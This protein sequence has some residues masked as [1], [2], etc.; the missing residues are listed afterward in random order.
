MCLIPTPDLFPIPRIHLLFDQIRLSKPRFDIP[1][2][3]RCLFPMIMNHELWKIIPS[4]ITSP[5]LI[6]IPSYFTRL[7]GMKNRYYTSSTTSLEMNMLNF[8]CSFGVPSFLFLLPLFPFS[9]YPCLT[10]I[11]LCIVLCIPLSSRC[12]ILSL[13]VIPP[14]PG[15]RIMHNF[16]RKWHTHTYTPTHNQ[17]QHSPNF[18]I[19][20]ADSPALPL[21]GFHG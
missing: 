5:F 17:K 6:P 11:L 19:S 20:L 18:L 3:A 9:L 10:Q 21:N 15:L 2:L 14:L 12:P 13:N 16:S 4:C 7:V 1:L 8:M